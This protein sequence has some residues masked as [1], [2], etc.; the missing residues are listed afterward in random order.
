MT[1][2]SHFH[3]LCLTCLGLSTN[4]GNF[5]KFPNWVKS[6]KLVG[7]IW[8]FNGFSQIGKVLPKPMLGSL[9]PIITP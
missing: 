7:I 9:K 4:T 5:S 1:P 6:G 3:T 2:T 8:D